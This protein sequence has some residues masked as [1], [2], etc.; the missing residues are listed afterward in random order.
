MPIDCL[1]GLKN[2]K[3]LEN[4]T[5][6][7][8]ARAP[9]SILMA[10]DTR[11]NHFHDVVI[12]GIKYQK[13]TA[14]AD[15]IR[16]TF[17]ISS[18]K[19]GINFLGIGYFEDNELKDN[20]EYPLSHFMKKLSSRPIKGSAKDRFRY[21]YQYL[22]SLSKHHNTGQYV[23]GVMVYFENDSSYVCTFNTYNNTFKISEIKPG[24]FVDSEN[25]KK[26]FPISRKNIIDEINRRIKQK[27]TE[28][29]HSIG[30]PIEML[31][32]LPDNS[33][34]YIQQSACIYNGNHQELIYYFNNQI[35]KIN[36]KI[37]NPPVL[38]R[39]EDQK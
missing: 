10:S 2:V 17:Y 36:G 26:P 25:N 38:K 7:I 34:K 14:T 16:K 27:S 33:C 31:E 15:C 39:Y 12:K 3:Y 18:A 32:L 24:Q 4:T 6:I 1:R 5:Y 28:E 11:L 13:I 29:P 35:S 19:I 20:Q 37:I 23:K 9:N 30:G 22:I 21:I 8:T